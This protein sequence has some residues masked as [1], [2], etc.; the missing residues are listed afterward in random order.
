MRFLLPIVFALATATVAEAAPILDQS[1]LD[2]GPYPNGGLSIG[3]STAFYSF[4]PTQTITAGISGTLT[5]VDLLLGHANVDVKLSLV[6]NPLT[7]A[8]PS[9]GE[10]TITPSVIPQGS[11]STI[12]NVDVSS[13]GFV[14]TAGEIFGIRL[15]AA[16]IGE[17]LNFKSA[18]W[19][20]GA[21]YPYGLTYSVRNDGL[22][23]V[24]A[25]SGGFRTYVDPDLESAPVPEPA[26]VAL[27]A[28]AAL[29]VGA[30]RRRRAI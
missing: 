11:H 23:T 13:I 18:S 29:A 10:I 24:Q 26:G 14:I 27:L 7:L 25:T 30:S 22:L 20:G 5:A 6:R 4:I 3:G 2:A 8:G 1:N 12:V 15:T 17:G 16:E 28:L 9:F 21:P 19:Q